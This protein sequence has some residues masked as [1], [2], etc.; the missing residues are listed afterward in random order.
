M[1]NKELEKKV[2]EHE[3]RVASGQPRDKKTTLKY[4]L[5]ISIILI[6]T[7]LAIFFA[8]KDNARE[9]W[10]RLTTAD[11]NYLLVI[12][13]IMA[14]CVLVR[15]FILFCFAHLFTRK[16]HFH[17]AIA[18]DQIGQFYNAITP[19][20]SG[21]QIMQAYTFKKQGVQVSSAVSILAMYS[22]VYQAVLIVFGI[23]SFI[24]KYDFINSLGSFKTGIKINEMPLDLPIWPLTIIGFILNLGVIAIVFLM[25]YWHGFHNFVMGPVVNLLSKIKIVK[26]PDRTRENLRIQVENFKIEF[27]RLSTNIPFLLLIIACFTGYMILKF[28]V[29]YFVGKALGNESPSAS[30]WDCIFLSNYHQMV[31][32]LVPVPGSVGVSEA[33]FNSLF[34]NASSNPDVLKT[35][36]FVALVDGVPDKDETIALCRSSLL[37]WRTSTFVIPVLIGGFVAA[38]YRSSPKNEATMQGD[39]PNRQTFFS[40][41]QAT[42]VE[43]SEEVAT[44]VETSKLSRDAI[45]E[46]LK[47][48]KKNTKKPK[49]NIIDTPADLEKQDYDEYNLD[50]VEDDR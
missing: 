50:N 35:G 36:F 33:V 21:G 3:E 22:I 43:R 44:L 2:Q 6:V 19:G 39:V 10:S 30:F 48:K 1:A 25:G 13:A 46:K 4:V 47:P 18:V 49:K 23:V 32:G 17:Q 14:G 26:N 8:I 15:S 37:V 40:L 7:A 38:F 31:T 45:I 20:A 27:R 11:V 9:I 16:Y 41:Q 5:N 34:M 28:S 24:V 29:P 12:L 42:F